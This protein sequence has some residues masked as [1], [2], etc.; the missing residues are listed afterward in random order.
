V[1]SGASLSSSAL[2]R[3]TALEQ[4]LA[5]AKVHTKKLQQTVQE[6]RMQQQ[7]DGAAVKAQ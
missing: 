6:L 7:V 3:I 5:A 4:E 1:A 2:A